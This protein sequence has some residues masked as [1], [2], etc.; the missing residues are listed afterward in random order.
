MKKICRTHCLWDQ[1][2]LLEVCSAQQFLFSFYCTFGFSCNLLFADS[3]PICFEKKTPALLWNG[4][5]LNGANSQW[6]YPGEIF[7]GVSFNV[8]LYVYNVYGDIFKWYSIGTICHGVSFNALYKIC[9]YC[10][11]FFI[12]NHVTFKW[13][14]TVKTFK[15]FSFLTY[16]Y[17]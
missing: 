6:Y 5:V 9:T 2:F 11:V 8:V 16:T 12:Y 10:T 13:Y 1:E 4:K 15:H 14:F 17:C 7:N 3:S